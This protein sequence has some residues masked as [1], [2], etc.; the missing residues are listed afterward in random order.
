M[1]HVRKTG[2]TAVK[3][4]L[5]QAD[6]PPGLRLLLHGHGISL[7]KLPPEDDVFFFLRDPVTAFVSSF[8]MRRR[9]GRPRHYRA[10]SAEERKAYARFASA[11]SLA[12]GLRSTDP[13][14]RQEAQRAM[15][16]IYHVSAHL[17]DWLGDETEIRRPAGP[18]HLHRLAGASR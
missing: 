12:V 3:A 2:G 15:H 9:E 13:A 5:A 6:I 11:Q 17:A 1:L 8:E 16:S 18:H 7:P 10:W 14:E 4:A